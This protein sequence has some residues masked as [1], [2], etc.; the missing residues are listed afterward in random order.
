[1]S[2][3]GCLF[4]LGGLMV[5]VVAFFW[6]AGRTRKQ[7]EDAQESADTTTQTARMNR[8]ADIRQ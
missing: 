2:A 8:S 5:A 4:V 6:A 7:A 3:I 1:M